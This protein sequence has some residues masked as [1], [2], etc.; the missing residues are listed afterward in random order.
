MNILFLQENGI[1]ES[2]VLTDIMSFLESQGH[3]VHF[4]LHREEKD[5]FAKVAVFNPA[6]IVLPCPILNRV[7]Y[8]KLA[9]EFRTRTQAKILFWGAA[10]TFFPKKLLKQGVCDFICRGEGEY[11]INALACALEQKRP[12]ESIPNI[13]FMN[14]GRPECNALGPLVDRLD[15]LPIA[16]RKWYYQYPFLREINSK[17]FVTSRGCRQLCSACWNNAVSA[18]YDNPENFYRRKSPSRVIEEILRVKNSTP[19]TSLHFSDDLF[20]HP[21]D[22]AWMDEL[23][24]LYSEKIKI[25][26]SCNIRPDFIDERLVR[27]LRTSG[28][29]AVAMSVESSCDKVRKDILGKKTEKHQLVN[30]ARLLKQAGIELLTFNVMCLPGE[31]LNDV[32]ETV[33]FNQ[34][35]RADYVRMNMILPLP[36]STLANSIIGKSKADALA[37]EWYEDV[38]NCNMEDQLTKPRIAKTDA[39]QYRRLYLLFALSV[40]LRLPIAFVRLLVRLPLTPL[41]FALWIIFVQQIERRF[42]RVNWPSGLKFFFHTLGTTKRSE[43]FSSI[44]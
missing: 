40:K 36:Y 12:Y 42:F 26:F 29:R 34:Q 38:D 30:A 44:Y 6:L 25:P 41:Y 22:I 37:N 14:E 1:N 32:L 28:C 27:L 24:A 3:R 31:T 15:L 7:W 4:L 20:Y 16:D 35:I 2:F 18:V 13:G 11:A 33:R 19:L 23:L 5:F 9:R 43:N 10:A 17:R 39:S 8:E 21:D